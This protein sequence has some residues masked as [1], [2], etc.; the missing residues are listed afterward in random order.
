M[1]NFNIEDMGYTWTHGVYTSC[2][3]LH[4]GIVRSCD[5]LSFLGFN[6]I[7]TKVHNMGEKNNTTMTSDKSSKVK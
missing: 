7:P 5:V 3:I 6:E 4:C 2:C 1:D